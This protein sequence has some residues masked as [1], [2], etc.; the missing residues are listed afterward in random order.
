MTVGWKDFKC[1]CG[2]RR[3]AGASKSKAQ[4]ATERNTEHG[5]EEFRAARENGTKWARRGW[6]AHE[7]EQ[8]R[9]D[10]GLDGRNVTHNEA[11]GDG[12]E[13]SKQ[14]GTGQQDHYP[15]PCGERVGG[16]CV[17]SSLECM[18]VTA[19]CIVVPEGGLDLKTHMKWRE[20]HNC[21]TRLSLITGSLNNFLNLS[22]LIL[23]TE[24]NYFSIFFSERDCR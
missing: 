9:R 10:G 16:S 20:C 22:P 21:C 3:G 13:R 23:Q 7:R 12:K 6:G 4:D 14:K 18:C 2:A 5:G 8:R 15:S 1:I 24:I 11:G 19:V 17:N